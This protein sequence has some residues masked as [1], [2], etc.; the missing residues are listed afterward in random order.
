MKQFK[1]LD[2][3]VQKRNEI[4]KKLSNGILLIKKIQLLQLWIILKVI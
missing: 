1:E 3:I 4:E 2:E